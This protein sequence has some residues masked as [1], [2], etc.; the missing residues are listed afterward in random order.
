MNVTWNSNGL[1][2]LTATMRDAWGD[3]PN[4]DIG[5]DGVSLWW[6][7]PDRVFLVGEVS[8]ATPD[9]PAHED[10]IGS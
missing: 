4:F 7:A 3:D 1:S 6:T 2:L 8:M 10:L 9:A 5:D